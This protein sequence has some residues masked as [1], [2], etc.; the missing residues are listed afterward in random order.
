MADHPITHPNLSFVS[1]SGNDSDLNAKAFW[2]SVENK[3]VF[4][5]GQRP[6]DAGAQP[7]YD[8]R[9]KSLFGSLLTETALEWYTDEVT[10][11]TTW[12]EL[13][14]LFLKRFTDGRDRFKHRID[15]E[16]ATRQEGELIKNYFHRIKTSVDKGWPESIDTTVHADA[17]AQTLEKN[18]Q[19]RQRTQK[20]IDFSIKGLKPLALKQ[21]AHEYMIENPNAGWE[22]FTNHI[23]TKDLTFIVATDPANKTSTDKMT[24]LETQIKELT[25]LIKNQEVS[26]INEQLSFRRRDPDVKGRPNNTRFCD[27]CRMNGHS[28]S[29]CSK[30]QVQDEVNKLRKELTIKMIEKCHLRPTINVTEI[31]QIK[32]TTIKTTSQETIT[33]QIKAVNQEIMEIL[34]ISRIKVTMVFVIIITI[35]KTVIQEIINSHRTIPI[36]GETSRMTKNTQNKILS[37]KMNKLQNSIMTKRIGNPAVILEVD[38]IIKTDITEQIV[39]ILIDQDH[40]DSE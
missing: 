39:V 40:Q 15:A 23:I 16:N 32:K 14:N 26:A 30:K 24:S 10:N 13:K 5:L 34:Q 7:N 36:P 22:T 17:D 27:Y 37:E 4:S 1:F 8:H 33:L 9:Q 38:N 2:T 19:K 20:Y 12:A 28:I 25:K 31:S 6:T 3:I 35:A 29:R 18:I 21:K 11:T